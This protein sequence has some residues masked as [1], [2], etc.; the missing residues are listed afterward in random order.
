M[1]GVGA[2]DADAMDVAHARSLILTRAALEG[3]GL[4][5]RG[6]AAATAGGELRRIHKG[7]YVSMPTW[8]ALYPEDRH[9]VR[10][11]AHHDRRRG[12]ADVA[13]LV[14]A[15]VLLGL[16]L[17]RTDP[18]KIHLVAPH[19]GGHVS[20]GDANVARHRAPLPAGDVVEVA[21]IPCTSLARTAA[22]L[23]RSMPETAGLAAAD[24]AMR[25]SAWSE[26]TRTYDEDAAASFE[27]RV[28]AR[29]SPGARGVRRARRV[30]EIV[31][32]RAQLP[33]E[34]VSRH[35]LLALGF[36][37]PRLQVPVRGPRGEAWAVDFGLDD[38]KAWGEFD[39]KGKYLDPALTRGR[40]L[41]DILL[42]EKMREDWIRGTTGRPMARWADEHI[43]TPAAL[44]A[45][46]ASF[47]IFPR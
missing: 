19:A 4:S 42:E 43:G 13:C 11:V 3:R 45:R 12:S 30:L 26:D 28:A 2:R 27:E 21:G 32:G 35:H 25:A 39:G 24:A 5:S 15:A 9:L 20:A 16:P 8:R 10:V 44:A 33:G 23:M 34:S 47:H 22:D 18:R 29:L 7:A 40:S 41:A 14:S 17:Y 31:D 46:L 37:R 36:A 1:P 6:I 38:A